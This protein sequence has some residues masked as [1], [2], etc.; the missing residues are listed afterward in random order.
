MCVCVW[1][2]CAPVTPCCAVGIRDT[3]MSRWALDQLELIIAGR[4]STQRA[5]LLH[6]HSGTRGTPEDRSDDCLLPEISSPDPRLAGVCLFVCIL[7]GFSR[8]VCVCLFMQVC[9]DVC[10]YVYTVYV[11]VCVCLCKCVCVWMY[12]FMCICKCVCVC[13]C[14]CNV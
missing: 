12:V 11:S 9:V 13:V 6:N 5:G 3:E 14:V 2:W 1:S 10:F 8:F 4:L 7:Y